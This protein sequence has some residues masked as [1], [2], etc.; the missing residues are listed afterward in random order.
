MRHHLA[1]LGVL[2]AACSSAEIVTPPPDSVATDPVYHVTV[3]SESDVSR[4]FLAEDGRVFLIPDLPGQPALV[5]ENGTTTALDMCPKPLSVTRHG[6][7][8]CSRTLVDSTLTVY[9]LAPR[10]EQI[11]SLVVTLP[12]NAVQY[13][14][15]NVLMN[16]SLDLAVVNAFGMQY[17]GHD[18]RRETKSSNDFV[19]PGLED[20]TDSGWLSFSY[21]DGFNGFPREYFA[22]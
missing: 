2:L 6:L 16:D 22:W 18:G 15:G 5:W 12:S 11:D 9:Y 1:L 20:F 3:V 7:A 4:A 8:L 21:G 17:Y 13:G 10:A 14:L 19:A